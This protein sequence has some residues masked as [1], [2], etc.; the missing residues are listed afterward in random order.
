M[1]Q[2]YDHTIWKIIEV[3]YKSWLMFRQVHDLYEEKVSTYSR[4]RGVPRDKLKL[5]PADLAGLIDFLK[6]EQL[7]DDYLIALKA[8]C[9]NIF[10]GHDKTDLLDRYV[11]DIFHE[12][13][14][15]KEEH[16]TVQH[17]APVWESAHAEVEL[18]SIMAEAAE[19]FP[20]KIYHVNFLFQTALE[21]IEKLLS[22]FHNNEIMLRSLFLNRNGLVEA[23]YDGG[24][25]TFYSHIFP[26]T[27]P[28]EG[29]YQTGLSFFNSAFF[30]LAI[31][32]F[33]KGVEY[34]RNASSLTKI[35][36]AFVKK[37]TGHIKQAEE[38]L[39][40]KVQQT[41]TCEAEYEKQKPNK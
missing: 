5:S 37:C 31:E 19:I 11:S 27:G 4:E 14:I 32:A 9:H 18:E 6:L 28:T 10:R 33:T 16:Y 8:H 3:F 13:S 29:Y 22:N 24:I 30:E 17:Y 12:I 7:R 35:Q 15:L 2:Q 1:L 34:G 21:R 25:G 38:A 23:A 26:N 39:A 36:T 41:E 40:K 20:K